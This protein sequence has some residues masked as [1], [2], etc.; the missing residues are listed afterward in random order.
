M[1]R[2]CTLGVYLLHKEGILHRDIKS[3]NVLVTDDYS[4]KI[5]DFGMAKLIKKDIIQETI[6]VNTEGKGTPV[7]MAPEVKNPQQAVSVYSFPADIYSLGIV[8]YELFQRDLPWDHKLAKVVLPANFESSPIIL[9]LVNPNP[10]ARPSAEQVANTIDN[11]IKKTILSVYK[12]LPLDDHKIEPDIE[13]SLVNLYHNLLLKPPQEADKIIEQARLDE[14]KRAEEE[15]PIND[16]KSHHKFFS[17]SKGK[18]EEAQKISKI[19]HNK[20]EKKKD[21][22]KKSSIVSPSK[23]EKIEILEDEL[24][25]FDPKE[26][27]QKSKMFRFSPK[28]KKQKKL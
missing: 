8:L 24:Y 1:A 19:K 21:K 20:D 16:K 14:S 6:A 23:D 5:T 4:C 7:W 18:N 17:R 25:K 10:V 22:K 12:V 11:L 13:K 15:I 2:Y 27:K 26:A 28:K 3:L 9:P